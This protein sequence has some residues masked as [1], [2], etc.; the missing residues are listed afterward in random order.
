MAPPPPPPPLTAELYKLLKIVTHMGARRIFSRGGRI[1][2]LETKVPQRSPARTRVG[3][4]DKEAD[5][6]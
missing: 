1:R 5:V 4:G 6:Y 2:G 3:P